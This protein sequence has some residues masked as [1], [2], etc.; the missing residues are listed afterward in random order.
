MATMVL[1]MAILAVFEGVCKVFQ[2]VG[3][4]VTNRRPDERAKLN[5]EKDMQMKS[6]DEVG[7][8]LFVTILFVFCMATGTP[9]LRRTVLIT[10]IGSGLWWLVKRSRANYNARRDAQTANPDER[11]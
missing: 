1:P 10:A 3:L 5:L 2:A 8:W 7:A 6:V 11:S 9:Q 4:E